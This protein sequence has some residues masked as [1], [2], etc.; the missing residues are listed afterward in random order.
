[1][2]DRSQHGF[3]AI[4]LDPEILSSPFRVQTNWIVIGGAQSCGKTTLIG[5]LA[6]KGFRT[7]PEGARLYLEAEMARGRTVHEIRGNMA[8]FQRGIVDTQ[9]RI[10]GEL[11]ASDIVLLDTGVPSSMAWW[12]VYGLNP[13]EFLRECFRHRYASVFLLDRL[14]IKGDGL[15]PEDEALAAFL[16]EW[17]RR[18]FRALGYSMV[19]V[20]VMPPEE[21]LAFVLERVSEQGR[22]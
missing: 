21:R 6:E 22:R 1:M 7:A 17:I 3:L 20:P 11:G 10:E 16:D 18:D 14:P 9:L 15:R 5:Q 2:D 19:R 13:N 12:R 8:A 4:E